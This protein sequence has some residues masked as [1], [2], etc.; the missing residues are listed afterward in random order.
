MYFWQ[1]DSLTH[2]LKDGS[3]PQSERIKYLLATLIVYAVGFELSFLFVEPVSSW[4]IVQ[5]LSTLSSR[6]QERFIVML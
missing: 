2:E 6:L 1:I 5:Q 4:Q 3:L